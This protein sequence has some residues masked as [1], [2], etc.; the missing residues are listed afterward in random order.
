[1][2]GVEECNLLAGASSVKAFIATL[3]FFLFLFFFFLSICLFC[4]FAAYKRHLPLFLNKM[5]T[6]W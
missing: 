1:M 6:F 3:S 4:F 5:G 2:M